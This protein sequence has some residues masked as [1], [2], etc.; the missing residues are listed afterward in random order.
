MG[1]TFKR[2]VVALGREKCLT[3]GTYRADGTLES[4][5]QIVL[6]ERRGVRSI[7]YCKHWCD[8]RGRSL[9]SQEAELREADDTKIIRRTWHWNAQ[10][11][12]I[13]G[14]IETVYLAPTRAQQSSQ[15]APLFSTPDEALNDFL[16][17]EGLDVSQLDPPR[18]APPQSTATRS[19]PSDA[20]WERFITRTAIPH[21]A[22][23]KA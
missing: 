19:D 10:G 8:A 18:L 9:K 16:N 1:N 4:E 23:V 21:R 22:K 5:T 3:R 6:R 12:P 14:E 15:L 17:R 7:L 20:D 11:Q 13:Q 2:A